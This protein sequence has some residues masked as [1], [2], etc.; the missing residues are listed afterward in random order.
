M[1]IIIHTMDAKLAIARITERVDRKMA[2]E[3]V[4]KEIKYGKRVP[5]PEGISVGRWEAMKRAV[6]LGK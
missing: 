5:A 6:S 3:A 2:R 1:V 4:Y